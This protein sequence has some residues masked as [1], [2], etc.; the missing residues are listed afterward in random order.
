MRPLTLTPSPSTPT[1]SPAPTSTKHTPALYTPTAPV[2]VPGG[3]SRRG[4]DRARCPPRPSSPDSAPRRCP[5]RR[6]RC[7]RSLRLRISFDFGFLPFPPRLRP[8]LHPWHLLCSLSRP[9]P[10]RP[11]SRPRQ[12]HPPRSRTPSPSPTGRDPPLP[13]HPRERV[14]LA[15]PPSPVPEGG[16]RCPLVR[17]GHASVTLSLHPQRF[18]AP[19]LDEFRRAPPAPPLRLHVRWASGWAS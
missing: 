1:S 8:R 5:W 9:R 15:L 17:A 19:R 14:P 7:I 3:R 4:H 13:A 10:P 16:T 2:P 18:S 12:Q 6:L 11:H